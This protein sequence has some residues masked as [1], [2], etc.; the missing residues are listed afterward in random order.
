[1]FSKPRLGVS[2]NTSALEKILKEVFGTEMTMDYDSDKMPKF[3][4]YY[5]HT[6]KY[7]EEHDNNIEVIKGRY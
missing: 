4:C 7:M 1:M 6:I 5:I 3:V 2:C